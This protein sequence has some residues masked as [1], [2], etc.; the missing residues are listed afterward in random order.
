[1]HTTIIECNKTQNDINDNS[2]QLFSQPLCLPGKWQ[3]VR[4]SHQRNAA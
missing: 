3:D 2:K 1:M 4:F